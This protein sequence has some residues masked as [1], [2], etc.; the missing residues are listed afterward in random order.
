MTAVLTASDIQSRTAKFAAAFPPKAGSRVENLP[1]YHERTITG[2]AQ[3]EELEF[4]TARTSTDNKFTRDE[5]KISDQGTPAKLAA[6]ALGVRVKVLVKALTP[7]QIQ[8]L[9]SAMNRGLLEIKINGQ[10]ERFPLADVYTIGRNSV[11]DDATTPVFA[12]KG[13]EPFYAALPRGVPIPDGMASTVFVDG[14]VDD[15]TGITYT[16]R[17]EFAA[18]GSP[19]A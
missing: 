8:T 18:L 5:S 17:V 19:Q 12:P 9:E 10:T 7:A 3:A 1:L 15:L 4:F 13:E 16:M 2:S 6:A 11:E 14:T